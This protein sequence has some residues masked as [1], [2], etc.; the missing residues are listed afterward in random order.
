M[1]AFGLFIAFICESTLEAGSAKAVQ[2]CSEVTG[3]ICYHC[4]RL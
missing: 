1:L 4:S 3:W 2:V